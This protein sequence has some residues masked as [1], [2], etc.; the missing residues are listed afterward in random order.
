MVNKKVVESAI[1]FNTAKTLEKRKEGIWTKKQGN[2]VG[3]TLLA[4]TWDYGVLI[5]GFTIE[6]QL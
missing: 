5:S 1:P 3:G 6:K 2:W 4:Y